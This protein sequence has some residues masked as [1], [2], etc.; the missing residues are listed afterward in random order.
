MGLP[1]VCREVSWTLKASQ[2]AGRVKEIQPLQQRSK[3]AA[4]AGSTTKHDRRLSMY[5]PA[6]DIF[7]MEQQQQED[8]DR[9]A[10]RDQRAVGQQPVSDNNYTSTV[11]SSVG[12]HPSCIR[13]SFVY[14]SSSAE[15]IHWR[16]FVVLCRILFMKPI[17]KLFPAGCSTF[18]WS[19]P[20]Q[21]QQVQQQQQ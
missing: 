14:D 3:N 12:K 4:M 19:K 1:G 18:S 17:I 15:I 9:S 20:E 6:R 13:H 8:L 7:S 16:C 2:K 5:D 10:E 21:R 11:V